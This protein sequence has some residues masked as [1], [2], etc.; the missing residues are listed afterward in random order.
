MP[1]YDYQCSTCGYTIEHTCRIAERPE[2][3]PCSN[4]APGGYIKGQD[5][6]C[7]GLMRQIIVAPAI[8]VD[9]VADIPWMAEFARTRKEAR[10]GG[11]P[12]ETR[13]EY[14]EYMRSHNLRPADGENLS[15]V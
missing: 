14:R 3:M 6:K 7:H 5:W 15:E 8:Q 9:T 12:I 2:T 10:F 13:A 4:T 1:T 11:K